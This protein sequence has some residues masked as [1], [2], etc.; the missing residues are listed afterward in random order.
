MTCTARLVAE[1]FPKHSFLFP[2]EVR[3]DSPRVFLL[4]DAHALYY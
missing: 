2:V 3:Y 1:E 4:V